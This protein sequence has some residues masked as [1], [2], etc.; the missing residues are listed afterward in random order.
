MKEIV[1]AA[2]AK[3]ELDVVQERVPL[4]G[5]IS[6][7]HLVVPVRGKFCEHLSCFDLETHLLRAQMEVRGLSL[8][9][10]CLGLVLELRTKEREPDLI[11]IRLVGKEGGPCFALSA[12]GKTFACSRAMCS[13]IFGPSCVLHT[14]Q[15]IGSLFVWSS[16]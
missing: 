14:L 15:G 12:H 9:P 3:S 11:S 6:Q 5:P 13:L 1:R 8:S 16:K 4:I 2:F 10:G 7:R